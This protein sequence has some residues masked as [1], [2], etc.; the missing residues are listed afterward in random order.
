MTEQNEDDDISMLEQSSL[1]RISW[2]YLG[3]KGN[4]GLLCEF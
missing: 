4:R 3:M 1:S 2:I